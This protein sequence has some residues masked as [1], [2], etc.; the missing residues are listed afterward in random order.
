VRAARAT[1][2]RRGPNREVVRGVV[3]G[4][5]GR[6]PNPI[7]YLSE[8]HMANESDPQ[9][10][11]GYGQQR[12]QQDPSPPLPPTNA[13][14]ILALVFAFIVPL[15]P[16]VFA[17]IAYRQIDRT[18]ERGGGLATAGL[19]LSVLFMLIGIGMAFE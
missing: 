5:A 8:E 14:A 19:M 17:I 1:K 9:R 3:P 10:P 2:E 11:T 18:G 4:A 7:R 16:I 6:R 15:L 12:P 13:M